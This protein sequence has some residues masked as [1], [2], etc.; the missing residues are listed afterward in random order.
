MSPW[1]WR[2]TEITITTMPFLADHV[3]GG[4]AVLPTVCALS[5]MVDVVRPKKDLYHRVLRLS[6]YALLNG[7]SFNEHSK[8]PPDIYVEIESLDSNQFAKRVVIQG[9]N[10]MN[11]AHYR[12][13][14]TWE[15][16][17]S[18]KIDSSID[19]QYSYN[20]LQP[21]IYQDGTLF[22]GRSLQGVTK[23]LN[24]NSQRLTLECLVSSEKLNSLGVFEC[25]DINPLTDDLAL[26]SLLIWTKLQHGKSSLPVS[27][28]HW[29]FYK[30]VPIGQKFYISVDIVKQRPNSVSA[31]ITMHDSDGVVY[32]EVQG[33]TVVMSET[34]IKKFENNKLN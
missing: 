30:P 18:N 15:L 3:F 11:L 33:A 5:E 2:D 9:K 16:I 25:R 24:M 19:L 12:A 1:S 7:L 10:K 22:H 13:D 27:F 20:A 6:N 14:V 31:R 32:E 26:Q 8:L 29:Y 34:L 28:E 21:N 23:L 4:Q 17:N